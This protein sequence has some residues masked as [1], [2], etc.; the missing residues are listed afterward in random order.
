ML[1]PEY[2]KN[3]PESM[4]ELYSGAEIAILEDMARRINGFDMFIPSAQYQMKVLEEM[5]A[6]RENIIA[7]LANRTGKSQKELMAIMKEAGMKS[8]TADEAVYKAAGLS[9]SPLAS[10]VAIK[11]VL[12]AGY[13]KTNG[14]FKNLTMTTAKTATKQFENALDKAYMQI[15]SGAIDSDTA[16]K[17]AV[18][19]LAKEGISAIEYPSGRVDSIETAVRRATVTGVNQTC[20]KM[21]EARAEELGW[22]LVEVTAHGGARPSH[23]EWQGKVYSLSGKS[24]KYPGLKDATGYGTGAGLKGWNCSHDFRPYFEGMPKTYSS[25]QLKE[26]NAKNYE[27]NGEKMTEYD[28]V[29]KQRQIEQNLRRWKRENLAMKAAGQDTTESAM[30]LS[31]WQATQKDFLDQTGLK[32]Q[33]ARESIAGWGKSE[34]AKAAGTAQAFN[35]FADKIISAG[36]T[37]AGISIA[38]VSTHVYAR[39]KERGFL[40]EDVSNALTKPLDVNKIRVDRSQRFIGNVV[41]SAINV[42]TGKVTTAWKTSTKTINKLKGGE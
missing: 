4:V 16:I 2:L 35:N 1:T 17:N 24:K 14:L 41:T 3:V 13:Q 22:D 21:Q 42:D 5:G 36:K 38:A 7:E 8:L 6:L 32:R 10:S 31:K 23:A 30:K 26:Y 12:E 11:E 9:S 27:Y 29:G 15:S 18:K 33:G 34:A 28:A 19:S 37:S 39:A 25:E 20:G 40:A